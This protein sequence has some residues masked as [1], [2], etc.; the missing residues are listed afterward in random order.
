MTTLHTG[1]ED[2][3]QPLSADNAEDVPAQPETE[4]SA[5]LAD[6]TESEPAELKE[7]SDEMERSL[8]APTTFNADA[9]DPYT[10]WK[11]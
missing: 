9:S 3:E 11:H 7:S 2:G 8:P 4:P 10:E 6:E 5:D 1:D